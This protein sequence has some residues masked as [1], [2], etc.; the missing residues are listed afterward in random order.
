MN[1]LDKYKG[2]TVE[3]IKEE[4]KKDRINISVIVENLKGNLNLGIITRLVNAFGFNSVYYYGQRQWDRRSSV[5]THNYTDV[6]RLKTIQELK[7]KIEGCLVLGAELITENREQYNI[8]SISDYL[9]NEQLS[10]DFI[11]KL[12]LAKEKSKDIYIIFG[13]EES[14]ISKELLELCNQ[15]IEIEQWGSVRSL[16]VSSSAAIIL[17]RLRELYELL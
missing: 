13:E 9:K 3:E 8:I 2:L 14:G 7:E 15:I 10:I 6:K 16:N 4:I 1:V 17:Y 11:N 5:G 12:N